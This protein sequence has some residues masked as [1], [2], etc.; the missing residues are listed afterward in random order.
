MSN[1]KHTPGPWTIATVAG[2]NGRNRATIGCNVHPHTRTVCSIYLLSEV[3]QHNAKLIAAAPDLLDA[4]YYAM[5]GLPDTEGLPPG[6]ADHIEKIRVRIMK[7]IRPT[8]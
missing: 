5:G 2:R 6:V 1:L 7:A 8:L 4:L 3:D